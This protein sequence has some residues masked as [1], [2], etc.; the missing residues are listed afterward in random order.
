MGDRF[1]V[2]AVDDG[3]VYTYYYPTL[4]AAK[5]EADDCASMYGFDGAKVFACV[6][7]NT[8]GQELYSVENNAT[9]MPAPTL[10]FYAAAALYTAL[11][12]I[13]MAIT[14][15][16]WIPI[17]FWQKVIDLGKP[18]PEKPEYRGTVRPLV[19]LTNEC[20]CVEMSATTCKL[21]TQKCI[22]DHKGE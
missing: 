19:P 15:P 6:D 12:Y 2:Q 4:E 22:V 18:K 3:K 9:R 21:G 7:G 13:V 20:R 1:C 16:V 8:V 10:G 14:S 17:T 11:P 5:L